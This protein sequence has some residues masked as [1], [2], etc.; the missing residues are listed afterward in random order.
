MDGILLLR[1]KSCFRDINFKVYRVSKSIPA[2]KSQ[3]FVDISEAHKPT[4]VK[5]L[6]L[7][8]FIFFTLSFQIKKSN[9]KNFVHEGFCSSEMLR[10]H[11]YYQNKNQLGVTSS[12]YINF[13]MKSLIKSNLLAQKKGKSEILLFGGKQY[14]IFTS[15]NDEG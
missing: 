2:A 15:R 11:R 6:Q 8:F 5:F 13:T 3:N 4:S 14:L 12:S 7:D 9:S 10:L 1:R